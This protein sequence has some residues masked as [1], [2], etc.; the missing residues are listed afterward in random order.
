[1]RKEPFKGNWKLNI[2]S[3][4]F[5]FPAPLSVLLNIQ[6]AGESVIFTEES[7]TAEGVSENVRIE[8]KFDNEIYPVIGS[9]FADGFAIRSTGVERW[10]TQVY[11]SGEK[12]FSAILVCASDGQSF[13]ED[14]ELADGTGARMS[15]LYERYNKKTNK[16]RDQGGIERQPLLAELK[17]KL[18]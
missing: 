15:L 7:I 4:T 18:S 16:D 5:T 9:G 14:V 6:V 8:A 13:R 3:S 1:M 10:E 11:K 17:T 2:S 12:I